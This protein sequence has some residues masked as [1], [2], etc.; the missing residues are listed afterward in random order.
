MDVIDG[1]ISGYVRAADL[2]T[3]V[4]EV[5]LTLTSSHVDQTVLESIAAADSAL[6]TTGTGGIRTETD[7]QGYYAF[8]HIPLGS[9]RVVASKVDGARP[10]SSRRPWWSP[11]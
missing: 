3:P 2:R 8:E 7:E 10:M 9:Y 6:H 5:V 1:K 11:S 4:R